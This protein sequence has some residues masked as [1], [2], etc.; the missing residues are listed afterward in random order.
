MRRGVHEEDHPNRQDEQ[1]APNPPRVSTTH[2][3]PIAT[4]DATCSLLRLARCQHRAR[5]G[6]IRLGAHTQPM[7]SERTA[8]INITVR[9]LAVPRAMSAPGIGWHAMSGPHI[10]SE[11][12]YLGM[13]NFPFST[14]IVSVLPTFL[15]SLQLTQIA[16]ACAGKAPLARD[17]A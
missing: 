3:F 11:S 8:N 12:Q 7:S 9:L 1:L 2:P 5:H 10:R 6:T 4:R 17:F 14:L 13:P 15:Y 16:P